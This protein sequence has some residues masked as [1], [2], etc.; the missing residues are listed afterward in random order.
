MVPY[1]TVL[2]VRFARASLPAHREITRAAGTM[3]EL[4][5]K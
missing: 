2:P 1:F 5:E 4:F 3:Q